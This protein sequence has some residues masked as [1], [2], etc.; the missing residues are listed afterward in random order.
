MRAAAH[1]G[2]ALLVGSAGAK[3]ALLARTLAPLGLDLE[4]AAGGSQAVERLQHEVYEFV[5]LATG[6]A[7]AE[8]AMDG[9]QTCKLLQRLPP[10]QPV[11][12]P[13]TLVLLLASEA[14]LDRLR[15]ERAG[16]DAWLAPPWD[17]AALG[18]I[19]EER[20]QWLRSVSRQTD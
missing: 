1:R 10:A 13:P 12:P 14:V 11:A 9:F 16:A 15:A 8:A 6:E 19:V 17:E 5:F 7:S 3:A 2:R 18:R 4:Q 20:A